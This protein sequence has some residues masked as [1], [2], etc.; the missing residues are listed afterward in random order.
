M[1]GESTGNT[2]KLFETLHPLERKVLPLIAEAPELE[3]LTEKS[4]LKDVEVVRALQWLQNKKLIELKKTEEEIVKLDSNGEKYAKEGLPE[5]QF[6]HLLKDKE[7][8][9]GDIKAESKLDQQEISICI[10]LLKSKAAIGTRK[11]EKTGELLIK[12][13]ENGKKLLNKELLEEQF[14]KKT[15]PVRVDELKDEEAFAFNELKK[16]KKIIAVEKRKHVEAKL[17]EL[18]KKLSR[19]KAAD[20][21]IDSLTPDML[22]AGKWKNHAFRRYDIEINVPRI[23]GGRRHFVKEVIEYVKKIWLELGFEEMTGPLIQTGFWNF[24]ALFTAQDHPVRDL[25]DTFYIKDPAKG[26]LPKKEIVDNVKETHENGGT[27][28]SKGWQYNWDMEEARKN[29]LRTHTTCLSAQT[30]AKLKMGDLPK[31]YFSVGR[32]YRNEALDYSHLFEFNQIEGIVV[33]P[34]VNFRHL[35][36][37]LKEFFKKMGYPKVRV[38]PAYFPYTEPSAEVDVYDSTKG[39]WLEL[40]GSGLFRPELVKPLIGKEVP[41]LAWGMGF[42]RIIK[43]YYGIDDLRELYSNDLKQLREIKSWMR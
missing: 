24:D 34:D 12:L 33:D 28:G 9:L 42:G 11:D 30:I 5:R 10:G 35:I 2:E 27:T 13:S 29:V 41:V 36:G 31:K 32:C 43:M 38:R 17:T 22:K 23:S 8:S 19:L 39:E 7:L 3:K 14:M 40:V 16:R 26:K 20:K 21:V 25:Q 18:G 4:G 37:Y 6:L 1:A 15:F